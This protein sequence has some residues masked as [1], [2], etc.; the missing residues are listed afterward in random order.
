MENKVTRIFEK[1]VQKNYGLP[2]FRIKYEHCILIKW[3]SAYLF[4]GIKTYLN[5]MKNRNFPLPH[6]AAYELK[7]KCLIKDDHFL[8][9]KFFSEKIDLESIYLV[10]YFKEDYRYIGCGDYGEP[11][12]YKASRTLEN[13]G[14]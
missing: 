5:N 11:A 8:P 6:Q 3:L 7:E 1:A 13:K 14:D 12:N 2:I 4:Y 9:A 10:G